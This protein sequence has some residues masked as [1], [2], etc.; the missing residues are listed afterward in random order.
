MAYFN[1]LWNPHFQ[2]FQ[3]VEQNIF[4]EHLDGVTTMDEVNNILKIGSPMNAL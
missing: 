1:T 4:D 3:Y 2:P